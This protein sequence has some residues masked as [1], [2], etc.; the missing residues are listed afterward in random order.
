ME[1][2][3][4]ENEIINVARETFIQCG[5]TEASMSDIAT[6]LGINRPTLHYYFRTKEKLFDSVFGDIIKESIE[7]IQ[8]MHKS[9]LSFLEQLDA[10]IDSYYAHFTKNPDLPM[11]FLKE[12]HRNPK[13]FIEEINQPE[14]RDLLM[15]EMAL[16]ENLIKEKKIK[17][18]PFDLT[19]PSFYMLL[20]TPFIGQRLMQTPIF[21]SAFNMEDYLKRWKEYMLKHFSLILGI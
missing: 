15:E 7:L 21:N 13:G 8:D 10:I 14:I 12:M 5:Y 16:Y 11:F 2:R 19:L 9:G 20:I 4:L 18:V 3:D 1:N 6:K 17:N